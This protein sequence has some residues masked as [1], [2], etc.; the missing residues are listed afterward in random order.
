MVDIK[1]NSDIDSVISMIEQLYIDMETIQSS[2]DKLK[3]DN[4]KGDSADKFNDMKTLTL[5]YGDD[6]L[7]LLESLKQHVSVLINNTNEFT[8][9]SVRMKGLEDAI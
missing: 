3:C 5:Q 4:W 2:T 9:I 1:I 7:F 6:I 8:S